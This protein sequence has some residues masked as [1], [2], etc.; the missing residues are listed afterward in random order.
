MEAAYAANFDSLPQFDYRFDLPWDSQHNRD[1]VL[2]FDTRR[3][4]LRPL[5][6]CRSES[7]RSDYPFTSYLML[8]RPA[9]ENGTARPL[10]PDA[11]L[12]VE[13]ARCGIKH[14]EPEDISWESIWEGPTPFGIG[15]L[16]SMHPRVVKALRVD[17]KVIDIP[18]NI[19]KRELLKL[20]NG[21]GR[22]A[23]QE[24]LVCPPEK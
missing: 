13:S 11:V 2:L 6:T 23:P 9:D 16:N 10:A 17:G 15:K 7:R 14:A 22:S 18:K 24:K 12:V 19:G 5:F 8:V 21:S 1:A 4:R 20:L 3:C